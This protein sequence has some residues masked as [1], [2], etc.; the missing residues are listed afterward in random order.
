M[1]QL[2]ETS[3]SAQIGRVVIFTAALAVIFTTLAMTLVAAVLAR[4]ATQQRA[5]A[6]VEL[7]AANADVT[8]ALGDVD[9][10]TD[11]LSALARSDTVTRAKL[12]KPDGTVLAAYERAERPKPP[13]IRGMLRT[14]VPEIE[15]S[16]SAN[17]THRGDTLGRAEVVVREP[18]LVNALAWFAAS[19]LAVFGLMMVCWVAVSG[20]IG[21]WLSR[22]LSRFAAVAREIR[23]SGDLRLR[24]PPTHV[25]EVRTLSEDFNAM[26]DEIER[27]SVAEVRN[28]SENFNASLDQIKQQS[29]QIQE[30]NARLS[31]LAFY[32]PL[33]NAANRVLLMDRMTQL[34][35]AFERDRNPFAVVALDLDNF[36]P[37]NDQLGHAVG[38]KYLQEVVR[39]CK[40]MLRPTD[41][42]AR[43]GGDEFLALLPG[44]GTRE[45]ALTV[46]RKLAACV[47]EAN[48]VHALEQKCTAS[49][50][51]VFYPLDGDTVEQVLDRADTAMYAAKASG[52]NRIKMRSRSLMS[53][54]PITQGEL[55]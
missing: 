19:S 49:I 39:R 5:D 33:T 8:L 31:T 35:E 22:P 51:V 47:R 3:T 53:N 28:L 21:R 13:A 12:I 17:V 40:A 30:H 26:L 18:Y 10:A 24:V 1:K 37:L 20:R 32:D 48:S 16:A 44:V 11:V 9:G 23:Y 43:M 6:F 29:L 46:A 42:F 34:I 54:G 41:T 2:R 36:K 25:T 52:R 45:D 14:Q 15:V 55:I 27:L 38:D 50:G 7:I 4:N